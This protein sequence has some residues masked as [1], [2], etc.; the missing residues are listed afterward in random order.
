MRRADHV[1][2]TLP[3]AYISIYIYLCLC[4]YPCVCV[5]K[6]VINYPIKLSAYQS[7]TTSSRISI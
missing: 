7:K 1:F 3:P 6:N 4:L 2:R 5:G